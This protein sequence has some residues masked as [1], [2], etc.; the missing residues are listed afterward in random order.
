MTARGGELAASLLQCLWNVGLL[1]VFLGCN[2]EKGPDFVICFFVSPP[3]LS[4]PSH[5][6]HSATRCTCFTIM[7][8][9]AIKR[10]S[11]SMHARLIALVTCEVIHIQRTKHV[12][13]LPV[14]SCSRETQRPPCSH[15]KWLTP[16]TTISLRPLSLFDLYPFSG[17]SLL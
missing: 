14:P 1:Q 16:N 9:L 10:K 5:L 6:S 2:G 7:K 13:M 17:V 12:A 15:H 4:T 8:L 3:S 11:R